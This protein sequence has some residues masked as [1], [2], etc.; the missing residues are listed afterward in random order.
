M[1]NGVKHGVKN[2]VKNDV[3]SVVKTR[4]LASEKQVDLFVKSVKNVM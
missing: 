3:K 4:K 2:G 1:K